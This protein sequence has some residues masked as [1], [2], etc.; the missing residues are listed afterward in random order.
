MTIFLLLSAAQK[1]ILLYKIRCAS[2]QHS[3]S[4][5][6]SFIV[7]GEGPS[8]DHLRDC[9][10]SP[11]NRQLCHCQC[12][13]LQYTVISIQRWHSCGHPYWQSSKQWIFIWRTREG[14][15]LYDHHQIIMFSQTVKRALPWPKFHAHIAHCPS[16]HCPG[17]GT[18]GTMH[19]GDPV[20][21]GG[22]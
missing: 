13:M 12:D 21:G 6:E 3:L 9:T 20:C 14:R 10:T 8:R 1:G 15:T 5:P 17:Q 11:I 19:W 7:P 4:P 22:S 18:L 16:Y 2:V